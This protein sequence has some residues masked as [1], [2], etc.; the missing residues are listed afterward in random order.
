MRIGAKIERAQVPVTTTTTATTTTD[1]QVAGMA[2]STAGDRHPA[3]ITSV[4]SQR[5]RRAARVT[6][7]LGWRDVIQS[8][9]HDA[10][11]MPIVSRLLAAQVV[12]ALGFLG[13]G[14]ALALR[15]R[16]RTPRKR[17]LAGLTAGAGVASAGLA[18]ALVARTRVAPAVT[19]IFAY[20]HALRHY[21]PPRLPRARPARV[22]GVSRRAPSGAL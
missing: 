4:A 14:G 3:R 17:L 6:Q 5:F 16:P 22:T 8:F 20:G 12:L 15:G 2:W 1:V 19:A 10:A 13:L 21:F 9:A 11:E 7:T 18:L